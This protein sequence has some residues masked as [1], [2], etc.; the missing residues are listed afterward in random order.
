MTLA[1]AKDRAEA[2]GVWAQSAKIAFRFLFAA[3]AV[4]AAGWAVSNVHQVQPDS[5]AVVLRF[6]NVV[7][8]QGA[9]LLIA[10]PQPIEQVVI[11]PSADRQ[12]EFHID[13]FD[14]DGSGP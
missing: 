7:R 4:I 3:V 12:I 14:G 13:R 6:G 11:L 2:N 10:W 1:P 5:R 9:G 8:Q